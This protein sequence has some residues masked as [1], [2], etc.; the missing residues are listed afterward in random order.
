[1]HPRIL[2]LRRRVGSL[3]ALLGRRRRVQLLSRNLE[4]LADRLDRVV[5][6][7]LDR[8]RSCRRSFPAAAAAAAVD[9]AE[10]AEEILHT[11]VH[12]LV[13][14]DALEVELRD[15]AHGAEHTFIFGA[16]GVFHRLAETGAQ[17]GVLICWWRKG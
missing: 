12:D 13:R 6:R 3:G 4:H 15:Q 8:R 9:A 5:R 10:L 16:Q 11:H 2:R 1:M 17:H 14:D 7:L